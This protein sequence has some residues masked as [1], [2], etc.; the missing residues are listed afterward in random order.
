VTAR[1]VVLARTESWWAVNWFAGPGGADPTNLAEVSTPTRLSDY[2]PLVLMDVSAASAPIVVL[3]DPDTDYEYS[4]SLDRA[5]DGSL[6][7]AYQPL[8]E[9]DGVPLGEVPTPVVYNAGEARAA[10]KP[11]LNPI[12][13]IRYAG[14][15]PWDSWWGKVS[16]PPDLALLTPCLA[17]LGYVVEAGQGD[18]DYSITD[19]EP[20]P[21]SS[22]E[23]AVRDKATAECQTA[24]SSD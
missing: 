9:V 13:D 1:D 16:G 11:W 10:G 19:L 5:P 24:A 18:Y 23:Q 7:R 12:W 14:T 15:A 2:D 17:P 8:P 4:P 21:L 22:E 20:A 3:G 6:V